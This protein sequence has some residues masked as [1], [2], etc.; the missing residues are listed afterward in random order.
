M[1]E[2][3]TRRW[4]TEKTVWWSTFGLLVLVAVSILSL[5]D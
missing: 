3:E 2:Q 1:P 5:W 4:T